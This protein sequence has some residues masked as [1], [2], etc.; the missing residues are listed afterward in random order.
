MFE[1]LLNCRKYGMLVL[2]PAPSKW[3]KSSQKSVLISNLDLKDLTIEIYISMT[4]LTTRKHRQDY[5]TNPPKLPGWIIF[6]WKSHPDF[7][8]SRGRK[9]YNECTRF[10][11]LWSFSWY[12]FGCFFR[13]LNYWI[14]KSLLK[15][16]KWFSC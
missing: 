15:S 3:V 11:Q 7:E 8:F 2:L 6:D 9:S 5:Y 10:L 12:H 4:S 16:L 14:K 13:R 1:P